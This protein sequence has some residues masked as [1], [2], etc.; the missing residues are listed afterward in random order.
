LEKKKKAAIQKSTKRMQEDFVDGFDKPKEPKSILAVRESL[1]DSD[2]PDIIRDRKC[3]KSKYA[4]E[5]H[6]REV[7][8]NTWK[9]QYYWKRRLGAFSG[10]TFLSIFGINLFFCDL[11]ICP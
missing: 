8:D 9:T 1:I 4:V 10:H 11:E 5:Q 7:H 2:V 6:I 3:C